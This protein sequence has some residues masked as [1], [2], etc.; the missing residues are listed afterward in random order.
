M[1]NIGVIYFSDNELHCLDVAYGVSSLRKIDHNLSV[2]RI[3]NNNFMAKFELIAKV[4]KD[5]L[6]VFLSYGCFDLLQ[7][8][9]KYIKSVNFSTIIIICHSLCTA[10]FEKLLKEIKEI[11]IA[12]IG[13]Y[14]ETLYELCNCIKDKE[15]IKICKGIAYL[16]NGILNINERR[17]ITD[18][19]KI[20]FPDRSFCDN[21][22]RYFH[23]Y[24]SRG[25]EGCCTFCDRNRL[26]SI[27]NKNYSRMRKIKN[28]VSEVDSLVELYN[29]KFVSFSDPTF[30][31]TSETI[32]RLNELYNELSQKPYW[33]QFNFNVRAEQINKEV[34]QSLIRL[35]KCGLGNV[36]I[37][38]ESFNDEDLKLF[39]KK[40]R[41]EDIIECIDLLNSINENQKEDY[42]LKVEYGFINFHPYST[43]GGLR[44][45]IESFR[46]YKLMLNPYIISSKLTLNSLTSLTKRVCE[47]NLFCKVS[48]FSSLH[49]L[50]QYSINYKFKDP[51]VGKI[52]EMLKYACEKMAV[53]N[54]NGL[55]FIRN[56]YY[57]FLGNDA[58]LD[59]YDTVYSEWIK[60]VNEFSYN[61]YIYY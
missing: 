36:F 61:I 15:S 45:N 34:I 47:D 1:S 24:G 46:K 19:N 30:L 3:D 38:I 42:R 13:E 44:N 12:V 4:N 49:D 10:H 58:I 57:H 7:K 53:H 40:A 22:T 56:R 11:D 25:C 8:L 35:K 26:Y 29:C 23:I 18:I 41:K 60:C 28:I 52:Y 37:G 51:E 39:G 14:E 17:E 16:E 55:E 27:H 43:P 2:F 20:D 59:R 9:C 5:L 48:S 33:V 54:D 21:S 6:V 31:S 32:S 50:M